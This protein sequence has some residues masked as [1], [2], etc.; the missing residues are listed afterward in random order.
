MPNIKFLESSI[1]NQIAAGEVIENPASVIKELVENSIDA[2]AKKIKIEIKNGGISYISISDNGKGINPDEIKLAFERHATSKIENFNDLLGIKTLGFRGE[3]LASIAA[4]SKVEAFSRVKNNISGKYIMIENGNIYLEEDKGGA[5]GTKIIVKNLFDN[6]P[7]RKKHLKS[8]NAETAAVSSFINRITLA[9]P[10]IQ[11]IY[12]NNNKNIFTS[13]GNSSL[14]DTIA[15]LF[16]V[17]I[18]KKIINIVYKDDYYSLS[19]YISLP[20][21]TRSSR[22]YQYFM[23]NGRNIYSKLLSNSLDEAYSTLLPKHRF[24]AAFI[25][26]NVNPTLID[27]NVHPRKKEIRW[28]EENKIKNI[29]TNTILNNIKIKKAIP[30]FTETKYKSEK[31]DILEQYK[32]NNLFF[33]KSTIPLNAEIPPKNIEIKEKN[34]HIIEE[35]DIEYNKNKKKYKQ[36]NIKEEQESNFSCLEAISQ[37]DNTFILAVSN[38]EDGFY[39]IDQHAAHERIIYDNLLEKKEKSKI[40]CQYLATP[41][42]IELSPAQGNILIKYIILLKEYGFC[43]EHFG[44]NTYLIRSVPHSLKLNPEEFLYDLFSCHDSNKEINKINNDI[45]QLI[46]CKSAIKAGEKMG[47]KE[48]NKLLFDLKNTK[49]PYTCPHG[50]PTIIY[51]SKNDLYKKFYR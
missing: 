21:L 3:A 15:S 45:L 30:G 27:V 14:L 6:I 24:P 22:G 18:T 39:I 1:I 17:D 23:V 48:S 9:N 25:N 13:P 50:R 12:K 38:N 34:N 19:G 51:I 44:N 8:I 32:Q 10:D 5:P 41:V 31:K 4:V 49:T 35:T 47:L 2:G 43:I 33:K 46:S 37:I 20:E 40:Y 29:I 26:I 7:A 16:G 42:S 11:F 36:D 28:L